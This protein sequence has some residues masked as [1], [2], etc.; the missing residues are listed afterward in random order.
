MENK[1]ST[2][3]QKRE[4]EE[5]QAKKEIISAKKSKKP[6]LLDEIAIIYSFAELRWA[7][8]KTK[9]FFIP[10]KLVAKYGK[11]ISDVKLYHGY[12]HGKYSGIEAPII[13]L[14][15]KE[16]MFKT[17]CNE[18]STWANDRYEAF[19]DFMTDFMTDGEEDEVD[20]LNETMRR[21]SIHHVTTFKL[22]EKVLYT[23]SI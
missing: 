8:N 5:E 11:E 12:L 15:D 23:L 20:K 19:S 14:D 21:V 13:I 16:Q 2:I 3:G 7:S 17:L 10:K 18:T 1:I 4:M 6:S 22:D 9:W